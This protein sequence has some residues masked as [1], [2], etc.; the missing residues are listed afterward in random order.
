MWESQNKL[1]PLITIALSASLIAF[2]VGQVQA[3]NGNRD[4]NGSANGQ[5]FQDIQSSI[6]VEAAARIAA[7]IAEAAIREA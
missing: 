3:Q 7:D 1:R 2:S 6:D 5:P 4:S